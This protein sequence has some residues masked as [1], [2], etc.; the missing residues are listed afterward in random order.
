[1]ISFSIEWERER[2]G[3]LGVDFVLKKLIRSKIKSTLKSPKVKRGKSGMDVSNGRK[4]WKWWWRWES[5]AKQKDINL[6]NKKTKKQ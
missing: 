6:K 3:M 4:R 5:K 2:S 1:M